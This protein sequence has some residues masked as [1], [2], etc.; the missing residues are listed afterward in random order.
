MTTNNS[1]QLTKIIERLWFKTREG[2]MKWTQILGPTTFETRLGD[3]SITLNGPAMNVNLDRAIS[4]NVKKLDGTDVA[5]S[6]TSQNALR[7]LSTGYTQITS[8]TQE[9]LKRLWEHVSNRDSELDEL[10]KILG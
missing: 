9:V 3:F 8:Q 1:S 10:I 2:E 5:K 4:I 7:S 6:S